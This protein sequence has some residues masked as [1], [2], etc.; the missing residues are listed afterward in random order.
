MFPDETIQG[1]IFQ[2]IKL[3]LPTVPKPIKSGKRLTKRAM[4]TDYKTYYQAIIDNGFDPD[5]YAEKLLELKYQSSPF[6]QF[7]WINRGKTELQKI[8]RELIEVVKAMDYTSQHIRNRSTGRCSWDCDYK[9]LCLTEKKGGDTQFIIE[10]D[11]KCG[12]DKDK[13]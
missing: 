12:L 1:A 3:D 4:S 9:E 8:E 5:D 13:K 11:F 10:S 2:A 6:F 7:D